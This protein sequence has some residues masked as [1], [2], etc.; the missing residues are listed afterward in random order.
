VWNTYDFGTLIIPTAAIFFI[1]A[2]VSFRATG[3][4]AAAAAVSLVKAGLFLFYFSTLFDDQYVLRDDQSYIAYGERLFAKG[5]GLS[6]FWEHLPFLISTAGGPHFAY[7]IHNSYA[8]HLFG[9]GYYAPVALNIILTAFMAYMGSRLAEREFGFHGPLRTLFFCFF[10]L[11]PDV[12]AWSTII[13]DKDISVLFL[14]VVLLYGLS[15]WF[16]HRSIAALMLLIP[17]STVL[18]FLRFY[19]P[20]LFGVA[21]MASIFV[22]GRTDRRF[23]WLAS[24]SALIALM[25][26]V[27]GIDAVPQALDLLRNDLVNPAYG[28]IRFLLTPIPL[29]TDTAYSFLDVPATVHWL[30]MPF[31]LFGALKVYQVG[32]PFS[33]FFLLYFATFTAVY[34]LFGELQG[35]RHRVQLDFAWA[36]FQFAGM[37]ELANHA[38]QARRKP[39]E[40]AVSAE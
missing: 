3:S 10:L 14:H 32:T 30:L 7:Y 19:V 6:N 16:Q 23:Y 8:F 18:L 13:N 40:T 25:I 36:V 28:L 11:M 22:A 38:R 29:N 1:A 26:A 39:S 33:R 9:H 37:L 17:A 24:G 27:I 5:I 12:L 4:F 31:A 34:S 2:A 20:L 21:F 35:P 15:L